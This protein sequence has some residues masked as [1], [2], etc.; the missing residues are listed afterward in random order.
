MTVWLGKG[1]NRLSW[2]RSKCGSP[3]PRRGGMR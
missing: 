3:E 2:F 1:K